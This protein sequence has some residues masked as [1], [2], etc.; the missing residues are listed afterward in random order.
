MTDKRI[1]SFDWAVKRMLRDKANFGILEG[2]F[3]VLT[4]R[5]M[6]IVEI[7]ESEAN[8][9][10]ATDKFN[11]V[12]VKAKDENGEIIIVEVQV[13]RQIHYLE[14]ILYGVS[15][16]ITEH[17]ALGDDYN[18]VKKV[19]SINILYFNFGEGDDYLYHGTT[20]F[21]GAHTHD[22]QTISTRENNVV[23]LT[24]PTDIFPE[25]FLIRVNE[26]NKVATTPLEEW[27]DYL[28]NQHISPDTTA[29]GLQEARQ[30][31]E[32]MNM[33]RNERLA[34][35]RHLENLMIEKD[36]IETVQADGYE[37]GREETAMK[38]A[39]RMLAVGIQPDIVAQTTGITVEQL[40]TYE[41][42]T[43]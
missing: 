11:R 5:Q 7:L 31:L 30:K 42:P 6:R 33:T 9:E 17:I 37:Q 35:E 24:T 40:E 14:R 3:Q 32:V 12:D 8:Q 1:I 43:R 15:K 39:Q 22:E 36:V 26:F 27:L 23:T 4:G 41:K 29:P 21:M 20:R 16:A 18:T 13:T 25:Y 19:Y 28:K 34:Y 10:D 2:L 38:I